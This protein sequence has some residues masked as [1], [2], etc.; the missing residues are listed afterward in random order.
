MN[1]QVVKVEHV[2][3]KQLLK[4]NGFALD[5]VQSN[6]EVKPHFIISHDDGDVYN[7]YKKL[8]DA[9]IQFNMLL[10]LISQIHKL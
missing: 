7:T 6:L 8:E 9:V 10:K 4:I 5:K 1:D 3:S 2:E